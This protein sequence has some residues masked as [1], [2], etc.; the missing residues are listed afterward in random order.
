MDFTKSPQVQTFLDSS[1]IFQKIRNDENDFLLRMHDNV[2]LD[3]IRS[4]IKGPL[5]LEE[6]IMRHEFTE[7]KKSVSNYPG[8][9]SYIQSE[10]TRHNKN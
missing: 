6:I 8:F 7:E 3:Y 9:I 4:I 1:D 10:F 5:T 2:K